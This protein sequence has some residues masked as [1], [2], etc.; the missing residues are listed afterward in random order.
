MNDEVISINAF[1]V[2]SFQTPYVPLVSVGREVTYSPRTIRAIYLPPILVTGV[3]YKPTHISQINYQSPCLSFISRF[4]LIQ[5]HSISM[6]VGYI[7]SFHHVPVS[8]TVTSL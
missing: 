7:R 5:Y 1:G 6:F 2:A 3:G 4:L 8:L